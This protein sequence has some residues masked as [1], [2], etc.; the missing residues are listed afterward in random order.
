MG[1]TRFPQFL[2]G[3]AIQAG[4]EQRE[5]QVEVVAGRLSDVVCDK[6]PEG[7]E[8]GCGIQLLACLRVSG[9]TRQSSVLWG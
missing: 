1:N 8:L 4:A 5:R 3:D 9:V 6:Y 2:H 7:T